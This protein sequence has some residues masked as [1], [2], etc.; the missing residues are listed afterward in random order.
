MLFLGYTERGNKRS[1]VIL[2]AFEF[3]L[4][5]IC[6]G[7]LWGFSAVGYLIPLINYDRVK[8]GNSVVIIEGYDTFILKHKGFCN[9]C[10]EIHGLCRKCRSLFD[11][12]IFERLDKC[13][14]FCG[15]V[16]KLGGCFGSLHLGGSR[17]GILDL[18]GRIAR[19][20]DLIGFYGN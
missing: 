19:I 7:T 10:S 6:F 11:G 3:V 13:L 5:L 14:F 2:P 8:L 17:A 1:L 12:S 18:C 9:L 15:M 16:E 4:I 20:L